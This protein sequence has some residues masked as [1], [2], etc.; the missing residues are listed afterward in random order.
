MQKL[1]V[2]LTQH[3]HKF[4]P[5]TSAGD[6]F[7]TISGLPSAQIW[8][9]WSANG[10]YSSLKWLVERWLET[11]YIWTN[12]IVGLPFIHLFLNYSLLY[13]KNRNFISRQRSL[14]GWVSKRVIHRHV[15]PFWP[16][17]WDFMNIYDFWWKLWFLVKIKLR[18]WYV[19]D[20]KPAFINIYVF[21]MKN[22]DF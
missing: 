4:W 12:V 13:L 20:F 10:R 6:F 16:T 2:W 7:S 9:F 8:R 5:D 18:C 14:V 1:H 17:F 3:L 22:I 21:F 11:K 15:E 19:V